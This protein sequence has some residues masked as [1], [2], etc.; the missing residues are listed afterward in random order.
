MERITNKLFNWASILDE[1]TLEQA[2]LTSSMPFIHPHL[3]LMPDAHL[4]KG[5]T[6]GSVI[7]TE[8]AIMPAAIGVDIGCGMMA[9]K[10]SKTV[11]DLEGVDLKGL[12]ES[13]ESAIPLSAFKHNQTVKPDALDAAEELL[14]AALDGGFRPDDYANNW[15]HQIGS[16]G[17][18]NH[19]I[20]ITKD[21]EGSIWL[22]LHS[23]SRGVGNKIATHHIAVAQDYAKKTSLPWL[24]QTW[25]TLQRVL[26]N[27]IATLQR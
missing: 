5:S 14:D 25:H 18:G 12:R 8:G 15:T 7:P 3:A 1:K 10:T 26:Q 22:F 16:L 9:I 27:L 20:E 17:S 4:G 6:V 11:A 24:I 23:G 19:F 21:E 2:K 13:I